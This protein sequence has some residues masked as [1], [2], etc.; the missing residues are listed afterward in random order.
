SI[1]DPPSS[2]R[3][4]MTR[5]II[6]V[7]GGIAGLAAAHRLIEL[8]KEKSLDIEVVLL[9]ASA[10]LGGTIATERVGDFLV[11]AGPDS[12]I[13]EKPWALRLCERLGL[14]SR[15]VPT[16]AAYQK[17]YVVHNGRLEPLPEGFFLLA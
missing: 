13:T 17:I 8:N 1:I 12:F 6:V 15:L 14:T 11:E 3:I 9:E 4:F 10:R 7:G 5:R 2:T 16:Q